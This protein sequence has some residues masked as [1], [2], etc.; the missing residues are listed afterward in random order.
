MIFEIRFRFYFVFKCK[1]SRQ[2]RIAL[3][4]RF[5]IRSWSQN[6]TAQFNFAEKNEFLKLFFGVAGHVISIVLP[7]DQHLRM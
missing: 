5:H 7:V 1:N 3:A 2:I 6:K 4:G